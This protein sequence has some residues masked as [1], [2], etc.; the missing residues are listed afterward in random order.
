MSW[1]QV[2]MI[3]FQVQTVTQVP[4]GGGIVIEGPLGFEFP[5]PCTPEAWNHI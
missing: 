5:N 1:R 2:D 3:T 4:S